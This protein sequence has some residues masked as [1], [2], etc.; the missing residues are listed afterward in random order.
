MKR[1]RVQEELEHETTKQQQTSTKTTRKRKLPTPLLV[2]NAALLKRQK[3]M[4]SNKRKSDE[5][6]QAQYKKQCK[7]VQPTQHMLELY[8]CRM[9][10]YGEYRPIHTVPN[11][12]SIYG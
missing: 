2:P 9:F 3:H 7:Y 4:L 12:L 11:I 6:L 5:E 10:N 8:Y 1:K